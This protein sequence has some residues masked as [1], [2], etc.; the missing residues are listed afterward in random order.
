MVPIFTA[1]IRRMGEGNIFSLFV[2]FPS[3]MFFS[4]SFVPG[5]FPGYPSPRFFPQSLV[6]GPFWG[7]LILTWPGVPNMYPAPGLGYTLL[8]QVSMGY[9]CPP[10]QDRTDVPPARTGWGTPPCQDGVHVARQGWGT[11]VQHEQ[12]WGA[13][14][15]PRLGQDGVSSSHVR[16]GYSPGQVRMGYPLPPPLPDRVSTCY[17][18]AIPP[19]R[20][21]LGPVTW[22][23]TRKIVTWPGEM[24]LP[25]TQEDFVVEYNLSD[26][27]SVSLSF[28]FFSFKTKCLWMGWKS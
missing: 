16:M 26:F 27:I 17:V 14:P 9:P 6:R 5:P 11:P 12:D 25:F 28:L 22:E 24:P 19:V 21:D 4:R 8:N 10:S 15:P 1:S 3:P 18:W 2:N 13:A 23:R 7:Y 20:K